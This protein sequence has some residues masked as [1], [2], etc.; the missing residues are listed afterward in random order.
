M[1][2]ALIF[3]GSLYVGPREDKPAEQVRPGVTDPT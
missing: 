1:S 2:S 3:A